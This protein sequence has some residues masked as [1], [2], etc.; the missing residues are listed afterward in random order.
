MKQ[1]NRSTPEP[2]RRP[3]LITEFVIEVYEDGIRWGGLDSFLWW[4]LHRKPGEKFSPSAINRL[5]EDRTL[6]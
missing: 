6:E 4:L 3:L 1:G 2:K 5:G